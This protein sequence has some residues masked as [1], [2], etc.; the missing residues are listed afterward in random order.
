LKKRNAEISMGDMEVYVAAKASFVAD[1][2]ARAREERGLPP[3][4]YWDPVARPD[5][6]G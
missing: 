1:L 6:S 5:P 3:E 2:L 4:T